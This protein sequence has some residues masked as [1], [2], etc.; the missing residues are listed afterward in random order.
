MIEQKILFLLSS[1]TFVSTAVRKV[2]PISVFSVFN[3]E[4]KNVADSF[5]P[6]M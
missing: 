6:L 1:S 5:F 2:Y 3:S 4:K